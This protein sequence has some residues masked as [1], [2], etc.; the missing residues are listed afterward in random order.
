MQGSGNGVIRA[1][2]NVMAR[3]IEQAQVFAGN[4]I[5]TGA[6]LNC[7]VEAGHN[8]VISGDR[9]T[10]IGGT[11]TAV[12]QISAASIGNR[13]GLTTHLVIGLDCDFK[14]KMGE[15][16]RLMEDYQDNFTDA[17]RTLDRIA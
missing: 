13:A 12:E 14:S 6:L 5:N 15:I 9:G 1:G 11:V 10:I 8:V 17:M 3:F 16:D 7:E 4:E 2:G